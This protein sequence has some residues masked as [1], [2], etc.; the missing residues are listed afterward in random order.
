MINLVCN[1]EFWYNALYTFEKSGDFQ[2]IVVG[3]V[4]GEYESI[5]AILV[6][7]RSIPIKIDTSIKND[8]FTV[9]ATVAD[10]EYVPSNT[11]SD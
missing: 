10:P 4:V 8:F 9:G 7:G 2:K 11:F 1:K 3:E 6:K 5:D